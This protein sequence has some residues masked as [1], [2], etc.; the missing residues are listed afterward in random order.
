M[1]EFGIFF[2]GESIS[3]AVHEISY[4]NLVAELH[5]GVG[6][7]KPRCSGEL[8][9]VNVVLRGKEYHICSPRGLSQ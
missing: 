6:G 2:A 1:F 9:N 3:F 7:E 5:N 4:I 8:W